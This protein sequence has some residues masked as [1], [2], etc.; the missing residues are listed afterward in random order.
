M[1]SPKTP[2]QDDDGDST[3]RRDPQKHA[4]E[5]S[6]RTEAIYSSI[7]S[8]S[9]DAIISI[10]EDQRITLFNRGAEEIFCLGAEEAVG[11]PLDILIPATYREIH[12]RHVREFIE[13]PVVAR[14]M[15][16]RGQ[17]LGL[18]NGEVFPVDASISKVRIDGEW[19]LTAVLRDI[20]AS[21]HFEEAL[22]QAHEEIHALIEAAP[23]AIIV[24]DREGRVEIWNPAAERILGWNEGDVLGKLSPA[25]PEEEREEFQRL[26]ELAASGQA[27][28]GIH[29]ERLRKDG[30]RLA[31][32][33]SL[34]PLRGP[35]D[36][37]RGVITLLEDESEQR[38]AEAEKQHLIAIIEATPDLVSTAD[39]QGH[40]TYLNRAGREMLGLGDEDV[41]ERI[42]PDFYPPWAAARLLG[43]AIPTAIREG[44]WSGELALLGADGQQIPVLQVIIA[45]RGPTGEVEYLSTMMRDITARKEAEEISQFFVESSRSL[46]SSIEYEEVLER[47]AEVIVPWMADYCVIDLIEEDSEV[48]RPCTTHRDPTLRGAVAQLK[49]FPASHNRSVGPSQVLKTGESEVIPEVTEAWLRAIAQNKEHHEIL[50]RLSP[51]SELIV[52][53]LVRGKV[54]GAVT[55]DYSSSGRRYSAE[56]IPLAES[57]AA[58]A[59]LAIDNARL[60]RD[61]R[62]ALRTRDEV[63]RVVAH[64]LRN[65]LNT[66]S[67]S[68]GT[69]AD[70]LT[71]ELT[72]RYGEQLKIIQRSTDRANRLIED[73]LDVG[74]MQAGGISITCNRV[75]VLP[76][77][78][79]A[80]ALQ[81]ALAEEHE[82]QI[83]NRAQ[84]RLPAIWAD[85]H[86]ILQLFGNLLGNA[87]KFT[88]AAGRISINAERAGP[89]ILFSIADTGPG[90]SAENLRRI[91]IPFWQAQT[92]SGDGA[93]LGLAIS[94]G[95]VTAHG[96][97]I[98]AESKL[99]AGTT[100]YF[101]LPIAEPESE[102]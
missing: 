46:A 62:Q 2:I 91:F 80:V 17:V 43:E 75:E 77:L 82:L 84:E 18:R 29:T 7:I 78:D 35:S 4:E 53:L 99:G 89:R 52:P 14:R 86:R 67:L 100:F 23:L 49:K 94:K 83:E 34:A 102:H 47:I 72:E 51:T 30:S 58:R 101:T 41:T 42:A 45:H 65:P 98:W 60:Y 5:E 87:I 1:P 61:L 15:G 56:D 85:Q 39:P 21:I 81:R 13:S 93:G 97:E 88:P 36:E 8:I 19:I 57:L 90:I 10:D 22:K 73:L 32:R 70:T 54:I 66:I 31:M 44:S 79:E 9:A 20:T 26:V 11:Q 24:L 27:K 55:G 69:M 92:E 59:A 16:E 76:L 71:P 95:I 33:L 12:R 96:G 6:R 25:H 74:R 63:L 38:R 40:L 28:T 50:R 68:A 64:D 3:E 48:I 37:L